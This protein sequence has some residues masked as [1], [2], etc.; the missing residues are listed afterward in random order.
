MGISNVEVS[1]SST[2]NFSGEIFMICELAPEVGIN[3]VRIEKREIIN[4]LLH[5]SA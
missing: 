4:F 5:I 1:F 2:C 3:N